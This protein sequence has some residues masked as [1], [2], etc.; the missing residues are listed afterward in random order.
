M[1]GAVVPPGAGGR[2]V[3]GLLSGPARG[4]LTGEGRAHPFSLTTRSSL[5]WS[6]SPSA[7]GTAEIDRTLWSPRASNDWRRMPESKVEIATVAGRTV[8]GHARDRNED[9]LV[10]GHHVFAVADGMGGHPA[11][12]VAAAMAIAAITALDEMTADGDGSARAQLRDAVRDVH[13]DLIAV[14][15]GR[16]GGQHNMGTTVAVARMDGPQLL[17]ASVGDSRAY[18]W[19]DG[20]LRQLTTDHTV[21]A[22]LLDQGVL[23]QRQADDHPHRNVLTRSV[24]GSTRAP[25]VDFV[26]T[27]VAARDVVVLCTDGLTAALQDATIA[28][29]LQH[30]HDAPAIANELVDLALSAGGSDNITVVAARF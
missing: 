10:V 9:A 23:E 21:V 30:H 11:G 26:T 7:G 1:L 3:A 4:A 2:P 25:Q 22:D 15:P 19:H 8:V 28:R 18:L 12:G 14:S 17:V 6:P 16:D 24:G 13:D 20:Q 27:P 29:V 5:M